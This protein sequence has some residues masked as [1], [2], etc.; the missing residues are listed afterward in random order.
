MYKI[1]AENICDV[2]VEAECVL[3]DDINTNFHLIT[4]AEDPEYCDIEVKFFYIVTH[5]GP[6]PQT[7]DKMVWNFNGNDNYLT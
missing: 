6:K 3:E 1:D 2:R 7:F 4:P 5:T